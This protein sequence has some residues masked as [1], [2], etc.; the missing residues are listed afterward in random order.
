MGW[1][2]DWHGAEGLLE[3]FG[4]DWALEVEDVAG[5]DELSVEAEDRVGVDRA[6]AKGDFRSEEI[7]LAVDGTAGLERFEPKHMLPCWA[8][9]ARSSAGE[10]HLLGY[11]IGGEDRGEVGR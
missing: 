2:V 3:I 9:S 7:A 6:A 11:F 4:S 8:G 10:A 1:V 5:A